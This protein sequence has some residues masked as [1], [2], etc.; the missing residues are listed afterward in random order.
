MFCVYLHY[1]QIPK[2]M[3]ERRRKWG[4]RYPN[5]E[6]KGMLQDWLV[7]DFH[8]DIYSDE[9]LKEMEIVTNSSPA[10]SEVDESVL[11]HAKLRHE[12]MLLTNRAKMS[13]QL[14]D[15]YNKRKLVN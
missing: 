9:L 1:V 4:I 8:D 15:L 11:H 14:T 7:E 2:L 12:T 13:N 6:K 5:L 10:E 3:L